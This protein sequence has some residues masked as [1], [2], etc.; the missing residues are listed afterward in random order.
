MKTK[1][2]LITG[3]NLGEVERQLQQAKR[4]IAERAGA[5]VKW[6][7]IYRSEPWGQVEGVEG[8]EPSEFLNQVLIVETALK[9]IELLDVTEEIERELGRER[10]QKRGEKVGQKIEQ[11]RGIGRAQEV[12]AGSEEAVVDGVAMGERHYQSRPID[13]DILF[14]GDEVVESERLTI[15][16]PKIAEREFVLIPL[17]EVM[18][19]YRHPM[20]NVTVAELLSRLEQ[21]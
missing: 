17:C 14:Y 19:D 18:P 13:I 11:E 3:G 8:E 4:A 12:E 2:V 9:P 16:H 6:S 15:P 21:E 1:A 10:A 5:V 20:L 7:N